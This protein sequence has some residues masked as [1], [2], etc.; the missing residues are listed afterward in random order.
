MSWLPTL[1]AAQGTRA[2]TAADSAQVR[3]TITFLA[4]G[5]SDSALSAR[6]RA[7]FEGRWNVDSL[8]SRLATAGVE[9]GDVN[10]GRGQPTDSTWFTGAAQMRA[11]VRARSGPSYRELAYLGFYCSLWM[12]SLNQLSFAREGEILRVNVGD[13]HEL[14]FKREGAEW[15]LSMVKLVEWQAE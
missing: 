14:A 11:E 2:I 10:L 15:R 6:E 7:R 12:P 4:R 13:T 1:G 8:M 3:R 9:F 5:T